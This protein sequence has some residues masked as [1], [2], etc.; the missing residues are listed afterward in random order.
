MKIISIYGNMTHI[1][2]LFYLKTKELKIEFWNKSAIGF[3]VHF[4]FLTI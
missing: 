1:Y 2:F 3:L 4:K